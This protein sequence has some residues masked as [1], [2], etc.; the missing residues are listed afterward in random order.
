LYKENEKGNPIKNILGF[1]KE[2][3]VPRLQK[4]SNTEFRI[5]PIKKAKSPYDKQVRKTIQ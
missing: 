1:G 4:I 3:V 5:Q 2:T